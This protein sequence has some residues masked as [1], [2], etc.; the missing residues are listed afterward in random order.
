MFWSEFYSGFPFQ[1]QFETWFLEIFFLLSSLSRKKINGRVFV[2]FEVDPQDSPVTLMMG[3][4]C[5]FFYVLGVTLRSLEIKFVVFF[6]LFP[7][8]L[9]ALFFSI[10]FFR[11]V[12]LNVLS[13]F[14]T[15]VEPSAHHFSP[16][17]LFQWIQ[18]IKMMRIAKWM[19]AFS[20]R[21]SECC[22]AV[23]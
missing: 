10:C 11:F 5:S 2:F 22:M 15:G 4:F 6:T 18:K 9:F 17:A 12:T 21:T 8:F 23:N 3:N 16:T 7:G 20:P 13:L 1:I 14:P 19:K